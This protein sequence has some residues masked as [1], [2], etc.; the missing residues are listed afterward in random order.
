MKNIISK[1][2]IAIFILFVFVLI[3]GCKDNDK[4]KKASSMPAIGANQT[5]SAV[6]GLKTP[7]AVQAVKSERVETKD[8]AVSV[9]GKILKKSDI[10]RTL[11]EKMQ[12]IKDKIPKGKQKEVQETMRQQI[13]NGFILKTLLNNEFDKRK[14]EVSKEDIKKTMD[15][16]AATIPQDQK[17]ETYLRLNNVSQED[18]IFAIR[19]NKFANRVI[20]E[21]VK[22]TQKEIN[23]FYSENRDKLFTEPESV[24]VRHILVTL[25]KNDDDKVKKQKKE[26]IENIRKQLLKG[27]N[28][29]EL[30]RLYSD[31]PSKEVGGDL[32]FIQRGQMSKSFEDAAFSQEKDAIGPVIKTE[33]G[34]HI[35]QVLEHKAGK[36]ISLE[37]ANNKI[38]AYL[39]RQK[40]SL[41]FNTMIKNLKEKA[42]IVIY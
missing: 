1:S 33:F 23:K 37:Q 21:K 36:K 19:V 2:C 4:N 27:G 8:I 13:V 25:G 39:V 20:G 29:T 16:L 7:D 22:P 41:A 18:V 12:I 28:F 34:Y 38:V 17:V 3:S 31:C 30:A 6:P 10:E 42:K 26:K 15:K 32:S 40:T 11:K 35:I 9:D 5:Q 14:I 24:H